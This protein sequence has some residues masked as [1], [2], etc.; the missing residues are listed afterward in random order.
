MSRNY[1]IKSF[2]ILNLLLL[3]I[4]A[5]SQT[6]AADVSPSAEPITPTPVA[7]TPTS[8]APKPTLDAGSGTILASE[9]VVEDIVL[10]K[11]DETKGDVEIAV[12]GFTTNTC[13]AVDELSITRQEDIFSIDIKTEVTS[14]DPCK[15]QIVAFEEVASLDIQDLEPGTYLIT[16]GAVESFKIGE[17]TPTE[18]PEP[19]EV[20]SPSEPRDCQDAALFLA[21]VTYPDNTIVTSG[22][23]FTKTWKILNDGD[24]T[25]GTGYELE[26][27]SGTFPQVVSLAE[28]FP[29]VEPAGS[30][31]LSVELT[32]PQT[33]GTHSGTWVIKRPEGDNI[34]IEGGQAFDLWAV[35]AVSGTTGSNTGGGG[36]S[37]RNPDGVICAESKPTY[38]AKLLQLINDF[39]AN[40]GLPAY[41]LQSQLTNAAHVHTNDMSCNSFIT[42]TGSDGSNW[43][44]RIENALS[45]WMNSE[46]HR[47]NILSSTLTQIGIGYALNP[48]TAASYY[49]LVIAVPK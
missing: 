39:R 29:V 8:N 4:T 12:Q 42:H 36:T 46:V 2:I 34:E 37:V 30:V 11:I 7:A 31:E 20:P 14:D 48:Q 35:V 33:K 10:Q 49:T 16:S 38:E 32:A 1:Q 25:W 40:N 17:P 13:T 6:P 24:C 23:V 19:T 27:A 26:F 28:P 44:G 15:E 45:W 21:D 5:C 9:V 18:V 3:L 41:E 47:N 22:E 43:F